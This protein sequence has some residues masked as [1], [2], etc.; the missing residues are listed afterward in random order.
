MTHERARQ[1]GARCEICPLALSGKPV[2]PR[3]N[4]NAAL[5]ALGSHP[6]TSEVSTG[7][8][9]CGRAADEAFW[10]AIKRARIGFSDVQLANALL[11]K[12]PPKT[13]PKIVK[14]AIA[15][16]RPRLRNEMD[17]YPKHVLAM[18]NNAFMSVCNKQIT[19]QWMGGVET[20]GYFKEDG[21]KGTE[22]KHEINFADKQVHPMYQPAYVSRQID[23]LPVLAKHMQRARMRMEGTLPEW[24]WPETH[25]YET[26]EMF[27][28]IE[29]I[30]HCNS[31]S[32]GIGSDVETNIASPLRSEL[33]N[34]GLSCQHVAVSV[35]WVI[36]SD[37][38]K[39]ATKDCLYYGPGHVGQNY[40]FDLFAFKTAGFD[41]WK[42]VAQWMRGFELMTSHRIYAPTWPHG[43]AFQAC[44]ETHASR[45]KDEFHS[46]GDD[47]GS[48]FLYKEE[49]FEPRGI[50]NCYDSYIQGW[51]GNRANPRRLNQMHN[52]WKLYH[53]M[54]ELDRVAI[55]MTYNGWCVDRKA[56]E[57][58]KTF[59]RGKIEE[60]NETLNVIALKHGMVEFNPRSSHQVKELFWNRLG[61]E[62]TKFSDTTGEP[63]YDQ[64]V[65]ES[66]ATG[67]QYNDDA[68][69]TAHAMIINRSWRKLDES[70][71]SG[72]DLHSIGEHGD[73]GALPFWSPSST[74]SNRW[75]CY[76]PPMQT[77]PK[78]K[79]RM[80]D[81]KVEQVTS[82]LRDLFCTR[83]NERE[84]YER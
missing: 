40:G 63:S 50:Y 82:G 20:G 6:G 61:A 41:F 31:W 62:S 1:L 79:I 70:Y 5:V 25:I 67:E 29:H 38:L 56:Y 8:Y 13:P 81:G 15:C 71:I 52:G 24:V 16:C 35:P 78:G 37:K 17:K 34:V 83:M 30:K 28:A 65:L 54:R 76:D 18:G 26:A 4:P 59:I 33:Y 39:D 84:S 21:S 60:T 74:K 7:R 75:A 48:G 68:K 22:S 72:L 64:N 12:V 55:E 23:L 2:F 47:A 36:A 80:V 27:A 58:H 57:K 66:I 53:M 77:V 42:L 32:N 69:E 9:Q 51:L 49:N 3:H 45:W 19:S 44:Y 11:C 43:L 14:E 10:P 46:G 73:I